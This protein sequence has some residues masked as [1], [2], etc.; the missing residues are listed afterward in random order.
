MRTI[1]RKEAA[2]EH[3][4]QAIMSGRCSP[5]QDLVEETLAKELGVSRTPVREALRELEQEGLVEIIPFKG[6]RVMTQTIKDIFDIFDIKIRLEGL[7]ASHAATRS[8]KATSAK[9]LEEAKAMALAAKSRDMKAY[10]ESDERYHQAIYE[11]AKS[12]RARKIIEDLNA[13]WHRMHQ[14]MAA[15]ESRMDTAAEEHR[16][17]AEAIKSGDAELSESEM[18]NHLENLRHAIK[19]LVDEFPLPIGGKI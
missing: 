13:Q 3:I 17:I 4:R 1:S 9:L 2:Y 12:E 8:S 18:R 16:R 14:G 5:G 6:A 19:V 10:L 15:I 7:C 11:G